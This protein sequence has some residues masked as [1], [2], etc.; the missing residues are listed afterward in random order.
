M[1]TAEV[2]PEYKAGSKWTTARLALVAVLGAVNGT[3]ITPIGLVWVLINDAF[4]VIGAALFQPFVILT[5]MVAWLIPLPGVF[6]ISNTIMGVANFLTGDPN[7]VAT[8]YWGI[9]GGVAGEI[10][11]AIYRYN[12]AR[13]TAMVI[14][15]AILYIPLTN[16]VTFYLYGWENNL[17]LWVGLVVAIIA[18]V[19]ES[20]LPGIALA[21]WLKDS[22]L[23]RGAVIDVDNQTS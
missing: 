3:L 20:A 16:I 8:I 11:L 12:P 7:G 1:T 9:A 15:A 13:R 21:K 14:L 22:G 17:L 5:S 10:A 18:I 23:L 4:G 19:V 6:I 2:K